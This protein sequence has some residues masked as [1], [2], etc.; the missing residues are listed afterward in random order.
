M[1]K[2]LGEDENNDWVLDDLGNLL[3]LE[4]SAEAVGTIC[5]SGLQ[6][7]KGEL[8]LSADY[9]LDFDLIFNTT[10]PNLSQINSLI[11]SVLWQIQ[12]VTAVTTV[13]SKLI[14][15]VLIFVAVIQTAYGILTINT[16]NS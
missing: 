14:R 9:G 13:E 5:K 11:S 16:E 8:E 10:P 4:D 6:T 2:T 15:Q 7:R 12:D 3:L 1:L